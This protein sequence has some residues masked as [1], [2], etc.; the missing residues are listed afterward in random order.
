MFDFN[1]KQFK[2]KPYNHQAVQKFHFTFFDTTSANNAEQ[3][4]WG[5]SHTTSANKAEQYN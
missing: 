1:Y 4:N 5:E 3:Y 2:Q